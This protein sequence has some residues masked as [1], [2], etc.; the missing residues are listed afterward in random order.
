MSKILVDWPEGLTRERL[1]Y[2]ADQMGERALGSVE[3]AARHT[4]YRLSTIAPEAPKKRMVNLWVSDLGITRWA[5]P[6]S[7]Y[8]D[9]HGWKKVGVGEV[10]E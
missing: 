2:L 6:Q 7:E 3:D 10:S 9:P 8:S 5:D 1:E 4:L